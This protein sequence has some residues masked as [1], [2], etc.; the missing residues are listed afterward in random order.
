MT[1]VKNIYDYINS[2]APFDTQ[3][4]WD[5][6][7]FI[8][9]EFRKPVKKAVLS[10]D[11]TKQTAEFAREIGADLIISHHPLIFSGIKEV[12]YGSA[13]YTV[14]NSDIACIC[15]HTNFDKSDYG[16]NS[17]LADIL[18]LKN[19]YRLE[20]G[21]VVVGEL[22]YPMSMDDF[23]ELVSQRL[24]V[25]GIRY[26]DTQ[27]LISSVAVGGGACSEFMYNALE[28]SDC[29]VTGDLKYHDML[30][31][32]ELGLAVISAGHYE[33]ENSPFLMLKDE[34]AAIFSDVEFFLSPQENVVKSI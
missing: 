30:D 10:L 33:T 34:L 9:G 12:K 27:R 13:V 17:K 1:T 31:A 20:N 29:F 14:V 3:E 4:E 25:S 24:N 6:S 19:Q 2:I 26:T 32:G 11:I 18:G 15:A 5:N 16:I 22:E 21:F 8:I 28:N 7:G 23:A